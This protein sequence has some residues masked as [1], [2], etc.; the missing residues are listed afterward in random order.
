MEVPEGKNTSIGLA[1]VVFQL[2]YSVLWGRRGRHG[3]EWAG[4]D[5]ALSVQV[6]RW[7]EIETGDKLPSAY[8]LFSPASVTAIVVPLFRSSMQ[9]VERNPVGQAVVL[10]EAC[11]AGTRGD[12]VPYAVRRLVRSM[13]YFS[14]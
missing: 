1:R 9:Q 11:K 13:A 6:R 5:G 12:S 2:I 8:L 4:A 7:G 3:T 14:L 10:Q